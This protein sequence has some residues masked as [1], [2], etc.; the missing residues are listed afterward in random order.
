ME[1]TLHYY[2]KIAVN[3]HQLRRKEEDITSD[4]GE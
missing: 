4:T 2:L 1:T 3:L